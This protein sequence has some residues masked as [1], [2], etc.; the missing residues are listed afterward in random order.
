MKGLFATR[1]GAPGWQ[2]ELITD[3]D[4]VFEDAKQWAKSQGFDRFRIV[5]V[6]GSFP[7]FGA[8]VNV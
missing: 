5:T 7:D 8:T 2:E 6:D 1:E 3:N 4:A